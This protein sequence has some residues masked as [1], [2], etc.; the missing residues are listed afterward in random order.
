MRQE[1][2]K[3]SCT[4]VRKSGLNSGIIEVR[5]PSPT[6]EPGETESVIISQGEVMKFANLGF[7]AAVFLVALFFTVGGRQNAQGELRWQ[8]AKRQ[9][10][11]VR[12]VALELSERR[13]SFFSS[14]EIFVAAEEIG[15]SELR[16]VKLVYEFLPYQP[17]LSEYGL[18]YSTLHEIMAVRDPGCDET[19]SDITR[20]TDDRQRLPLEYSTDA[21]DLNSRL[22]RNALPCYETSA[23][24]YTKGVHEPAGRNDKF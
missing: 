7:P 14:H 15:P 17:R 22:R 11:R 24:D 2:D 21:P 9:P 5:S 1:D 12:L 23:A 18:D 10:L 4:N 19:L 6:D 3:I 8:T 13:S 16:L 20:Q